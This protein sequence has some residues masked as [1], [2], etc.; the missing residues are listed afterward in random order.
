MKRLKYIVATVVLAMGFASCETEAVDEKLKDDTL[1]AK[2]ILRF[3]LNDKQTIVADSVKVLWDSGQFVI[4]SRLSILNVDDTTN[5]E[6][7][8]KPG[9]LHISC[10]TLALGNFPTG[11]S[12]ENPSNNLSSA[13]LAIME[14]VPDDDGVLQKVWTY[15][16]TDNAE[17]N[18]NAGY[19]NI[20]V[21][22]DKAKYFDGNFEYILFPDPDS[23][24]KPQ[25]AT[26]GNFNYVKY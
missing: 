19:T 26:K 12:L 3:E 23:E 1:T 17:E 11:L 24:L 7:R 16:S 20:S 10:S 14:M 6:T 21:I 5:P 4:E 15:Y 25:R 13:D 18:Q 9:Y 22:N 8:Y 2:P